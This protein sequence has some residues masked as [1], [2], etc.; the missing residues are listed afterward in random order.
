MTCHNSFYIQLIYNLSL[1]FFHAIFYMNIFSMFQY[2]WV[3][4]TFLL[5]LE[6]KMVFVSTYSTSGM[7]SCLFIYPKPII[8]LL[9][10][11]TFLFCRQIQ[12]FRMR[13]YVFMR[14]VSFLTTKYFIKSYRFTNGGQIITKRNLYIQDRLRLILLSILPVFR[15]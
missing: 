8:L 1:H 7:F 3:F 10:C 6:D 12:C 4:S 5:R 13:V 11:R 2:H 15:N 9:W 14:Y